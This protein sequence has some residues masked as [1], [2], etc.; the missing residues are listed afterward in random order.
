MGTSE[1]S[2]TPENSEFDCRGQKTLPWS[3]LYTLKKVSK[4]RCRNGLAWAIRTSRT[5]VMDERRAMNQIAKFDFRQLKVKNRPHPGVCKWSATHCWKALE[6]S[7]K[8][9]LNLISIGGLSKELWTPKVMG[10]Q[11]GTVSRLLL[12]SP[13]K[14]SHLDVGAVE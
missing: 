3:V 10:V 5:Q 7:Y 14:E 1:S 13:G 11:T 12:G 9:A 6:E 2:G 8:F 4:C